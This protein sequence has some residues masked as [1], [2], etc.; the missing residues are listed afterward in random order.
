MTQDSFPTKQLRRELA[1]V[2][3]KLAA[4]PRNRSAEV[5]TERLEKRLADA[6]QRDQRVAKIEADREAD[7]K[8]REAQAGAALEAIAP[9]QQAVD[10]G[11]G[12]LIIRHDRKGGGAV[13]DSARGSSAFGGAVDVVLQLQRAEG[14]SRPTLRTLNALSR[15]SATPDQLIIELT[16]DGYRALGDKT[17]VAMEEACQAINAV[18]PTAEA[19]ALTEKDLLEMTGIKRTV[20]QEALRQLIADN[21]IVR[22]GEGKRGDAYRYWRPGEK[23]SAGSPSVY[24]AERNDHLPTDAGKLSA[25]PPVVPAESNGHVKAVM[26]AV[27]LAPTCR[28]VETC[29]RSGPCRGWLGRDCRRDAEGARCEMRDEVR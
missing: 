8:A 23:L 5:E 28:M 14:N 13:G 20:R 27:D 19:G 1:D 22:L 6:E 7:A 2:K 25:G 21:V 18:A 17:A 29:A 26:P 11:L 12:V 9:L 16:E 4:D 10:D 15:F 3:G 24:A